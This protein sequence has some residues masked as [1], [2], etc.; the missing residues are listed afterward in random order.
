M[1]WTR[2]SG[3]R[4]LEPVWLKTGVEDNLNTVALRKL[5]ISDVLNFY[6]Q[7][8]RNR[9]LPMSDIVVMS[10]MCIISYIYNCYNV[11]LHNKYF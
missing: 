9:L 5:L 6:T 8:L 11:T 10:K 3:E 2:E 4:D 1:L 7:S